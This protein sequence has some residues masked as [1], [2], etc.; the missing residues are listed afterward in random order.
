M[1]RREYRK[2]AIKNGELLDTVVTGKNVESTLVQ[3][4]TVLCSSNCRKSSTGC[5]SEKV[6]NYIT[7][8][9]LH[10]KTSEHM[11]HKNMAESQVVIFKLLKVTTVKLYCRISFI[12]YRNY[13]RRAIGSNS[14][15]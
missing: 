2:C 13:E 12:K 5:R 14:T 1:E 3:R 8:S 4:S 10:R 11:Y 15:V 6:K 9:V 7:N